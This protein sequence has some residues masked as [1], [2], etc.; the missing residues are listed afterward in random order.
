MD[1]LGLFCLGAFV[2]TIATF[3]MRRVESVKDWQTVLGF[4]LPAV[5]SGAA[6]VFVDRF[7]FSPAFGCYP[8]GLAA[9]LMWAYTSVAVDNIKADQRS[10]QILGVLH[11]LAATAVTAC[12]IA[13]ATVP[14]VLQLRAEW[15]TPMV[16]RLNDLEALRQTARAASAPDAAASGAQGRAVRTTNI[17]SVPDV[18]TVSSGTTL[19]TTNIASAPKVKPTPSAPANK[20]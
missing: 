17:A 16:V 15:N 4:T 13:I 20:R 5:L 12:G 1:Y 3:G 14:A 2:G 18:G 7:K 9:A 11:L 10:L 8:L 6:M 19:G